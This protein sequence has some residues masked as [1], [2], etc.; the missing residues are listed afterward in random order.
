MSKKNYTL[1]NADGNAFA[2]L[3][4]VCTAM[5]R[6]GKSNEEIEKYVSDELAEIEREK[7][8]IRP[9]IEQQKLKAEVE[10]QKLKRKKRIRKR[11]KKFYEY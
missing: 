7:E 6:E 5:R 10:R 8:R 1:E 4:Y 9:E 3:T 2:I 11:K